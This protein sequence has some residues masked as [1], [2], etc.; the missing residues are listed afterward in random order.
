MEN[1]ITSSIKYCLYA[2]KST[3]DDER[4]A[5]SIDSQIKEMTDLAI[6][7]N[8]NVKEI[9]TEKHSAK[10]SG[11]R[12]VFNQLLED[13]RAGVFNAILTW[14][15]DRLSRNAGDLGILVD[16]MDQEKLQ[17]IK[18]FT[19][20]F[21]NNP[22]EKFLLMILCSQAKLENDNRGIN[23]KRGMR[24]KCEMGWRPQ[25][26][27]MGYLINNGNPNK[28]VILDPDRAFIVK[29]IFERVANYGH[30]G[31][32]IRKWLDRM[33]FR[34]KNGKKL[35]LSKIYMT[36][37]NSYYYGRFEFPL[38]SGKWYTGK[39]EPIISKALFDKVQIQLQ[40]PKKT[41]TTKKFP[42]K[43]LIRCGMCRS[44][45]TA[46]L[47]FRKLKLGGFNTHIYYHC[48]K[49]IDFDCRQ[50]YISQDEL[51]NQMLCLL[52]RVTFNIAGINEKL[53]EELEKYERLKT[54]LLR[55]EYVS[56]NLNQLNYP[57]SIDEKE[58]M[59]RNYLRHILTVGN[60]EEQREILQYIRTRFL[61]TD[62]QL[63]PLN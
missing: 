4:Q 29:Q 45:I 13:I 25:P 59:V 32:T 41:H 62:G 43:K 38:K 37:N 57:N 19:Q 24:A 6:R 23:V 18:T 9:R 33:D 30:S 11:R 63:I 44:G 46:E 12:P 50:P 60:E 47:R 34:T 39:H 16:L 26:P 53:K 35:A 2:R 8:L 21:S 61:L 22:N 1:N 51:V 52:D 49:S 27:P 48:A 36:L 58:E 10:M 20:S 42:F 40:A 31:R 56:G 5:M 15:P 14:A 17:Q 7:D 3:E 55:D 54:Q 28:P